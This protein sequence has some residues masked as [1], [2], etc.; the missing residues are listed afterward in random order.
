MQPYLLLWLLAY[1]SSIDWAATGDGVAAQP[2]LPSSRAV[3][4]GHHDAAAGSKSAKD[5]PP[6]AVGLG[7][8]CGPSFGANHHISRLGPACAAGL[9][10]VAPVV[11]GFFGVCAL[12]TMRFAV[13]GAA[14]GGEH[15]GRLGCLPGLGCEPL[16]PDS[17]AGICRRESPA[18]FPSFAPPQVNNHAPPSKERGSSP[19]VHA[20]LVN[21]HAPPS[22]VSGSACSGSCPFG[23]TC[24]RGTCQPS[25]KTTTMPPLPAHQNNGQAKCTPSCSQGFACINGRCQSVRQR[26]PPAVVAS[27]PVRKLPQLGER[28][29]SQCGEGL[30]CRKG[31]CSHAVPSTTTTIATRRG[32]GSRC[33]DSCDA[34]LVCS[35]GVCTRQSRPPKLPAEGERCTA[36]CSAGLVCGHEGVC[37]RT[38]A[39]DEACQDHCQGDSLCG[40][41]TCTSNAASEPADSAPAT[42]STE[43]PAETASPSP[44]LNTEEPDATPSPQAS[45]LTPEDPADTSDPPEPVSQPE[46]EATESPSSTTPPASNASPEASPASTPEAT[47]ENADCTDTESPSEQLEE[48]LSSR[49]SHSPSSAMMLPGE[50]KPCYSA[51]R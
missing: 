26:D 7:A 43:E 8:S 5:H 4:V 42:T 44:S 46:P 28:C 24:I 27:P 10:C 20:P 2:A 35:R 48:P 50:G 41:S 18:L 32:E 47:D 11:P 14:C 23:W 33:T 30:V 37:I 16:G 31:V 36:D 15:A 25:P 17:S 51:C 38:P 22:Q 21:N 40:D 49:P 34:G 29:I 3:T 19:V 12:P 6:L 1:Y 13:E 9:V 39:A 45:Q